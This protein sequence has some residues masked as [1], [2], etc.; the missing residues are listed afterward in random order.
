MFKL[1]IFIIL[2]LCSLHFLFRLPF[3]FINMS[4]YCLAIRSLQL[5]KISLVPF[6]F[7]RVSYVCEYFSFVDT[8]FKLTLQ[9]RHTLLKVLCLLHFTVGTKVT[10][11]ALYMFL[12][13]I[14]ITALNDFSLEGTLIEY[15]LQR[16]LPMMYI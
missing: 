3:I 1:S 12:C 2:L 4:T 15:C 9:K 8:F 14:I 13:S 10:F 6:T 11:R 7:S 16:I 5:P